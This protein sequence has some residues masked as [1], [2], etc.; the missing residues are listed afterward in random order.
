MNWWY[1]RHNTRPED[2]WHIAACNRDEAINIFHLLNPSTLMLAA[3]TV[4]DYPF[5]LRAWQHRIHPELPARGR[6]L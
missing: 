6:G 4:P 2:N 1:I 3:S 5:V